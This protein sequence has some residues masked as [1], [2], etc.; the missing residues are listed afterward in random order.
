MQ[1]GDPVT[2]LFLA[3]LAFALLSPLAARADCEGA[4]LLERM[5]EADRSA[6]RAATDAVPYP[7]GLLWEATR[8]EAVVH[9]VGTYHLDD[10]RHAAIF[11]RIVPLIDAAETVLVEAGPKEEAALLD[12]MA[13]DPS[14]IVITEGPT[15]REALPDADWTLLA[16]AMRA[17]GMPP[18]LVAKFQP[19]YVSMLLAVPACGMAEMMDEQG[20]LDGK[21]IAHAEARGSRIEALESHRTL[22]EMFESIPFEQQL[23]MIRS[24][25]AVEPQAAD[26]SVTLGDAYFAEEHQLIWEMTRRMAGTVPG[27]DPAQMERDFAAME[28]V[29]MTDRNRAWIPVIEAAAARGPVF[30][31]FGALHLPGEAGV[32]RLLEEA[33]FT[34]RRLPL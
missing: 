17:R 6:L 26:Y 16:D 31:A 28:K 10:L 21:V 29:M 9:I 23:G 25:L 19:W 32:L 5:S 3:A 22:V 18:F 4:N 24:S 7:R 11:D 13:R 1:K 27:A 8:E 33:G 14:M 2:R 30:A 20:G 12:Q 15:L 34:I